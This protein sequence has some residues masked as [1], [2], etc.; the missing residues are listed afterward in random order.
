MIPVV[1]EKAPR[2]DHADHHFAGVHRLQTA[3]LQHNE[4]QAEDDR[5]VGVQ[6][7]LPVVSHA[8]CASGVEVDTGAAR[9]ATG[10]AWRMAQASSSIG[11][12]PVSKTGGWGFDSLLA[13]QSPRGGGRAGGTMDVEIYYSFMELAANARLV[14]SAAPSR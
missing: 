2:Q 4:E 6:E 13:C 7:I 8:H 1:H 11:R 10:C 5:Q 12:A 9:T 3:Q 14:R